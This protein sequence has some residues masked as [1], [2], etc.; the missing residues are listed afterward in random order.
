MVQ[1]SC[2]AVGEELTFHFSVINFNSPAVCG[3]SLVPE[4]PLPGCLIVEGSCP[5]DWLYSQRGDGGGDWGAQGPTGCF[6]AGQIRRGFSFVLDPKF[7]CYTAQYV[8]TTGLVIFQQQECFTC[9]FP[10]GLQPTPWTGVK[11]LYR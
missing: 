3:F 11:K 6:V 9:G 1:D 5:S 2:S 8:G 7:C 4:L 10:I